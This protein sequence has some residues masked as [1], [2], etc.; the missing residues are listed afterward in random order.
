MDNVKYREGKVNVCHHI[1]G[2]IPLLVYPSFKPCQLYIPLPRFVLATATPYGMKLEEIFAALCQ[3][4]ERNRTAYAAP[5]L[6]SN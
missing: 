1:K 3:H 4:T 2:H 5:Y 6:N